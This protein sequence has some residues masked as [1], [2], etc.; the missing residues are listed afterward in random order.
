MPASNT[1]GDQSGMTTL[2]KASQAR[3][4]ATTISVAIRTVG[5]LFGATPPSLKNA[6]NF[7]TL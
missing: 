4:W 6:G 1:V 2:Q 5:T 7:A 3:D